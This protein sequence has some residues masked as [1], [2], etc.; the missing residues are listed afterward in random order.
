MEYSVYILFSNSAEKYYIGSTND[1][2]RRITE[3]NET[4]KGF[5][6]RYRPW[7]LVYVESLPTRSRAMKLEK[8]LK[9]LHDSD[10]IKK[11]I[12]GWRSSTS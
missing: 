9:S 5:T 1:V 12:A 10:L 6:K 8:Y 3:H 7:K 2:M 11:Y 4:G